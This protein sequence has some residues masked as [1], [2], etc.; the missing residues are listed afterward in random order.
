MRQ[1]SFISNFLILCFLSCPTSATTVSEIV[2]KQEQPNIIVRKARTT[3]DLSALQEIYRL[4]GENFT[5]DYV[6]DCPFGSY[7]ALDEKTGTVYGVQTFYPCEKDGV[8]YA[9]PVTDL[10][11]KYQSKGIGSLLR[12]ET[13]KIFDT[14]IGKSINLAKPNEPELLSSSPLSYILSSN[15]W[16]FGEY[17]GHPSLM[18]QL[19]A[20][21][22]II[23]I[24]SKEVLYTAYPPQKGCW[25]MKREEAFVATSKA[26]MKRFNPEARINE[27]EAS[28]EVLI[29]SLKILLNDLNF[30]QETDIVTFLTLHDTLLSLPI[31]RSEEKDFMH[32]FIKNLSQQQLKSINDLTQ[33]LRKEKVSQAFSADMLCFWKNSA[34]EN[35]KK[36]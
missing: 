27:E 22:G 28:T 2:E 16:Y 3:D 30:E 17:S 21:Y 10:L 4:K 6:E 29:Q 34:W 26:L 32:N 5:E 24:T 14:F 36:S 7:I 25:P 23:A 15:E 19:K 8:L 18:S 20:G 13:A 31:I 33:D 1:H 35:W 11:E 9:E 12:R